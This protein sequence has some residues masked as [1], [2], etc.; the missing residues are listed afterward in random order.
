MIATIKYRG[1]ESDNIF[2]GFVIYLTDDKGSRVG[3]ISVDSIILESNPWPCMELLDNN[4][5]RMTR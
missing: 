1:A 2:T 5:V 4:T 3:E